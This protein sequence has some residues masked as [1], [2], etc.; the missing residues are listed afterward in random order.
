[1]TSRPL[2]GLGRIV[3]GGYTSEMDGSAPG[4]TVL[5]PGPSP[6]APQLTS[7]FEMASPSFVVAHPARPWLFAVGEGEPATVASFGLEESGQLRRISVRPTGGDLACHLALS[8][9][10]SHLIVANYGSGSV[11]SF[12]IG[13]DG[14]LDGP[15]DV[16]RFTG[17]GP[18]PERQAA[19]HAHQ[20]LALDDHFLV[21]DLGTDRIHRL[22][23]SRAGLVHRAADPIH[24]PAGAG[25]RH[26]AVVRDLLVVAC[27]LNAE[28]W[29]GRQDGDGWRQVQRIPGTRATAIP[30][31]P[32]GIASDG[33]TVAVATR[34]PDTIST[35]EVTDA[36]L[37]PLA[38]VSC[39]GE[40]PRALDWHGNWLWVANQNDGTVSVLDIADPAEPTAVLT[41]AAPSATCVVLLPAASGEIA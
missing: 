4:L 25:P 17:S 2:D 8:P 40:W 15:L 3:V 24:L 16:L 23:L 10:G 9:D 38:E 12:A 20:V 29:V 5:T 26:A 35:F 13:G 27:E 18:V 28:L 30:R 19:P 36:G 22:A 41:F 39:G 37:R 14:T 1:M 31:Q 32:S 21:C 6:S 33:R 34:G 11:S 7:V